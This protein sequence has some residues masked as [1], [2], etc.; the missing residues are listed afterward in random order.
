MATTNDE[1]LVRWPDGTEA[2][3][4]QVKAGEFSFMSDDYELVHFP[5]HDLYTPADFT[6]EEHER[7]QL[8]KMVIDGGLGI[9]KRCG[10]GEAQ[11]D[12][13]ATCHDMNMHN[14]RERDMYLAK[15]RGLYWIDFQDMLTDLNPER[16]FIMFDHALDRLILRVDDPADWVVL[17]TSKQVKTFMTESA[18]RNPSGVEVL[19]VDMARSRGMPQKNVLLLGYTRIGNKH[20]K[21][22]RMIRHHGGRAGFKVLCVDHEVPVG[23]K[24]W[25][26]ASALGRADHIYGR[27][28]DFIARHV[29]VVENYGRKW[30]DGYKP[31]SDTKTALEF[32]VM[33]DTR[34][35]GMRGLLCPESLQPPETG[36]YPK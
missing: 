29:V 2:T 19:T 20:S 25:A 18:E 8:A 31:G 15:Q 21:F 9:C 24:R 10:A 30:L 5:G 13:F 35:A 32:M 4:G 16:P 7:S 23:L 6:N 1:T 14:R 34:F 26:V 28:S 33:A 27:Y 36:V 3:L 22:W 12:E 11:L 17:T